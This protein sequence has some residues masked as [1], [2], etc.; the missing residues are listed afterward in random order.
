MNSLQNNLVPGETK[1][2]IAGTFGTYL[3]EALDKDPEFYFFSP[4]ETTS[5]RMQ[6]VYDVTGRAWQQK[7][8]AWDKNLAK[9]G[10]VVEMLS[11]NT[12]FAVL[13]GHILSGGRGAMTSYESFLPIISSQLDQHLKFLKQSKEIEWRPDYEALQILSTSCW[14]RQDHNGYTHQ[15]PALITSVL[16]KPSNLVN[17]FFPVDDNAAEAAWKYMTESKN[18][19]NL[20]TFNKNPQPRWIDTAHAYFQLENGGAS[21]FDF[22]SDSEPWVIVAGVGDLPTQEALEG[23]KLVKSVYP[24]LR[25]RFVNIAALSFGAIG[26]TDNKL[27]QQKFDD[28]FGNWPVVINFHGYADSLRAIIANYAD[29]RR[30]HIHGY[31]DQGSTTSPLDELARNRCSRWDV[32]ADIL[33][34]CERRD[35]AGQMIERKAKNGEYAALY[36]VDE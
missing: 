11:E 35:L 16:S 13:A 18:V 9:D 17:C 32:A 21:I 19:V 29:P 2:H 24:E 36:G 31:E 22:A 12:L 15:N 20:A 3:S 23:I 10:K 28:F 6:Q 14:Q 8:E 30:F 33:G 5:N 1:C 26:T 34:I 7:E 27:S 25:M 4:D